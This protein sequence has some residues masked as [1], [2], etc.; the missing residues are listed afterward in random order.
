M[1]KCL[2]MDVDGTLTDGKIYIGNTGEMMKAFNVKDGYAISTILKEIEILPI[3]ITK[4]DSQITYNRCHEL[5]IFEIYQNVDNK[6][7]L[8]EKICTE[9]QFSP[10][11]CAYIGDDIPDIECMHKCGFKACPQ[12]A[13]SDVKKICNYISPLKAGEGAVRDIIEYIKNSELS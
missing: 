10:S 5:G 11:E 6:K 12:D 4:R 9:K 13:V 3:I 7:E 2:F 1:I 8:L